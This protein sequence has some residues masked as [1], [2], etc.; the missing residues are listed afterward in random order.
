MNINSIKRFF[1]IYI[2]I[3]V[4]TFIFIYTNRCSESF[5]YVVNV[6]HLVRKKV[7]KTMIRK[8]LLN[9]VMK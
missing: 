5:N 1:F 3:Y 6:I 8:F 4:P 2:F 7:K 9:H